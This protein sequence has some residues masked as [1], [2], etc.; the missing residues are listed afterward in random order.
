MLSE[1]SR[2]LSDYGIHKNANLEVL[3]PIRG[4]PRKV[5]ELVVDID[6]RLKRERDKLDQEHG[7]KLQESSDDELAVLL[8]DMSTADRKI[9]MKAFN[10]Q[11]NE[12]RDNQSYRQLKRDELILSFLGQRKSGFPLLRR[13][14]MTG[15]EKDADR[16]AN[17]TEEE[18]RTR[19]EDDA[20]RHAQVRA[21]KDNAIAHNRPT[22]CTNRGDMPGKDYK[23]DNHI[24]DVMTSV[25]QFHLKSG[26]WMFRE[27]AWLIAYIHVLNVLQRLNEDMSKLNS[28]LELCLERRSSL[29]K[30][31]YQ[32]VLFENDTKQVTEWIKQDEERL[33]FT[34]EEA[35]LVWFATNDSISLENRKAKLRPLEEIEIEKRQMLIESLVGLYLKVP[36]YWWPGERG[37][38]EWICVIDSID[39][40]DKE[41]RYFN[42][43]C[44]GDPY[45][46]KRYEM[47]YVDVQ[48]YADREQP[49]FSSFYLPKTLDENNIDLEFNGRCEKTL[50]E[51]QKLDQGKIFPLVTSLAF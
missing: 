42:L 20:Q 19:Q 10:I 13:S 2:S 9:V 33:A 44:L 24:D 17:E 26:E 28:L 31:L 18:T 12:R 35:V 25:F 3:L 23:L 1:D 5:E 49:E 40:E 51:L 50:R 46:D 6:E 7:L 27:S 36:N 38:K 37:K 39:L 11:L 43:K 34:R 29:E 8:R 41:K 48:K 21:D 22:L 32:A 15:A 30:T 45:P 4:G 47:A 16:R 14:L